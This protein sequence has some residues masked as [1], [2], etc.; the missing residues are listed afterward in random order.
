MEF[1]KPRYPWKNYLLGV[2]F[3]SIFC[4]LLEQVNAKLPIELSV[5]GMIH[6]VNTV[7]VPYNCNEIGD[8]FYYLF[9]CTDTTM[10]D[11]EVLFIQSY[12]YTQPIVYKIQRL[13]NAN[14][15]KMD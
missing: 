5:G 15:K 11:K 1:L 9:Q 2:P 10:K 12:F 6:L 14:N 7:Y 4:L 3:K 8:A 13:F